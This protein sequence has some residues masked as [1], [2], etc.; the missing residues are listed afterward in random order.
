VRVGL[1][2]GITALS[3]DHELL[4]EASCLLKFA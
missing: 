1:A 4:L 2:A 3:G